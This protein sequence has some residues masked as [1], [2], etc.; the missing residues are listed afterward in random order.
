MP[1]KPL[2]ARARRAL[3]ALV[4]HPDA[5]TNRLVHDQFGFKIESAERGEL[6]NRE[7]ITCS[8]GA[9]NAFVHQLTDAGLR[10][11]RSELTAAPPEGTKPAD[12]LLFV[13]WQLLAP[14]LPDS[15]PR[16]RS[17]LGIAPP[18][19]S[20]RILAVY[21]QLVNRPGG[22]VGLEKLREHLDADREEVD[23][24]LLEMDGRREIH[25]EPDPDRGG[26]TAA[27]RHAAVDLAGRPMH[28]L[29]VHVR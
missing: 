25:L 11:C 8:R 29:R 14:T 2:S 22:P 15:L 6:E 23:S 3:V 24:T 19:L 28:L 5:T 1:N 16:L 10:Q 9:H 18:P 20:E 27:A 21:E 26:L 17:F 4:L 7:L 12:R 13:T